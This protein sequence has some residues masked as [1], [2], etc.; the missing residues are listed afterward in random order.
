VGE[1]SRVVTGGPLVERIEGGALRGVN[2][3]H[4]FGAFGVGEARSVYFANPIGWRIFWAS[5]GGSL[6]WGN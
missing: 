2:L 3:F 4:S 6:S 1:N 5:G